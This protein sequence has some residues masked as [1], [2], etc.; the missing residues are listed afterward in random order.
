MNSAGFDPHN[1]RYEPVKGI[2]YRNTWA[3][4]DRFPES[5]EPNPFRDG[6]YADPSSFI[7]GHLETDCPKPEQTYAQAAMEVLSKKEYKMKSSLTPV[8]V[9]SVSNTVPVFQAPKSLPAAERRFY[10]PRSSPSSHHQTAVIGATF[11]DITTGVLTDANC[12]LPVAL[13]TNVK[14]RGSVTRTVSA[15]TISAAAFAQYFDALAKQ[16]K[17]LFQVGDSSLLCLLLAPNEVQVTIHSLP[18]AFLPENPEELLPRLA[19]SIY[20]SKKHLYPRNQAPQS[21]LRVQG[22]QNSDLGHCVW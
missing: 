13:T 5:W 15:A 19:D 2:L 3:Y 17:N 8:Q 6:K 1:R 14:V 4:A 7:A 16:L 9:R 11:L 20:N 12:T 22:W 21:Q 10:A 18:L